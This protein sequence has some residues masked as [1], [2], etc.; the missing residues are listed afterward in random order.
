ML[1]H[2]FNYAK[3]DKYGKKKLNPFATMSDYKGVNILILRH[4]K[5]HI[6]F[7]VNNGV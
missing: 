7:S 6:L 3:Y 2:I 4:V 5:S 1:M